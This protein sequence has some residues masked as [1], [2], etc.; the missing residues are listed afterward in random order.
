MAPGELADQNAVCPGRQVNLA[1]QTYEQLRI[2]YFNGVGD[3]LDVLT[4]LDQEQQLRRDLLSAR[5]NLLEYRIAL[6]R[7]LAGGI[8]TDRETGT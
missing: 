1:R 2:Q 5:L 4:A 6:Y 7:A 3:Y 8:E